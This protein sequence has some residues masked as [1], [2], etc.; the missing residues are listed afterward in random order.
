[1]PSPVEVGHADDLRGVLGL[2]GHGVG[3]PAASQAGQHAERVRAGVDRHQ[4]GRPARRERPGGHAGRGLQAG[5]LGRAGGVDRGQSGPGA[6]GLERT[7]GP[8][9][10]VL[11]DAR[12]G[13]SACW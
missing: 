7:E 3:E 2:D 5:H 11:Q 12:P 6:I 10:Q 8:V 1:M 4:V 9:A 13:R